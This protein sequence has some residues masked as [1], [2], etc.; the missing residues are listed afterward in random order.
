MIGSLLDL[1]DAVD[2][3]L[4]FALNLF[5]CLARNRSHLSVYFADS[6]FHVEPFLELGLF[7]PERAHFG[8]C[9]AGNHWV[10][11][12]E[13]LS[14]TITSSRGCLVLGKVAQQPTLLRDP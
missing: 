7:R 2:R 8:K 9:V 14:R 12:P 10:G 1:K 6:N 4:R 3:E 13:T 11:Q 5:E